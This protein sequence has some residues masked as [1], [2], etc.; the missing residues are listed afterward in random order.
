MIIKPFHVI[1]LMK[2]SVVHCYWIVVLGN[3]NGN[4]SQEKL[5]GNEQRPGLKEKLTEQD[6]RVEKKS[7]DFFSAEKKSMETVGFSFISK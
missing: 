7:K 6:E 3:G 1:Q 4:Q 2:D 5:I